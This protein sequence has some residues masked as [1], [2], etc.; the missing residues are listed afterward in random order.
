MKIYAP[1]KD[2]NGVWASVRFINGVGETDNPQLISWFKK[3]GYAVEDDVK[4]IPVET[5]IVPTPPAVEDEPEMMGYA[6]KEK[7]LE[8]MN[9]LELR[10]YAKSIGL[11]NQIRNT[12]NRE[13]LIEIIRG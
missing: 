7:T 4:E 1:V 13:K 2:A 11:G 5:F 12:R 10:E 3:N 6:P 8:D 9:P